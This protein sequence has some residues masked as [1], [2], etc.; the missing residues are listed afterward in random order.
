M[1]NKKKC[2]LASL[3]VGSVGIV[4]GDIGTS[5]LYALKSCFVIGNLAVSEMNVLGLISVFIWSLLL[6][7]TIKYINIVMRID[8]QGEGGIL[9]LSSIADK[10]DLGKYA[11]V[12]MFMGII[13]AALIFGDGVITP[14]ISV[15]SA[16]EG[17]Q[18]ISDHISNYILL[19]GFIILSI[20]FYIQKSGSGLIGTFFGPIMIIWFV[21]LG[22]LGLASIIQMPAILMALNPYYAVHFFMDNGLIALMT[23]GGVIL[24]VTGAEALYADMGHFG[25][26]PITLT[27][28]FFVFP[29]LVLNY[30]GQGAL[31]LASPEAIANPFYHLVPDMALY[32]MIILSTVATII[33]SQSILSGVFSL[34]WQAIMLNYLPRL[35]V[36]HTS[37]NQIGQVYVPAVNQILY[38]LTVTA[39]LTFRTSDNLAVAYGLSVS[40]CMLI[41]TCLA[42][43]VA[44]YKWQWPKI[45]LLGLFIPLVALDTTFMLTNI[46]KIV[47]GAWY[48]L[49]ITSFAS[50]VIFVWIRGSQALE[51]QKA[52]PHQGLR[53]FLMQYEEE[54]PTKIPGTAVFMTRFPTKVPN[55]LLI[56][57]HHNKFLHKKLL[58]VSI[59]IKNVP[60]TNGD[61]K[62]SVVKLSKH[63][64]VITAN[65][66]FMEVPSLR[67]IMNWAK[68]QKIMREDE[69]ISFFLSKGVP[70]ISQHTVLSRFG[71]NL[72]IFLSKNSLSAYE[73]Y[74]IPNHQVIELGVRYRV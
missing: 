38:V 69:D 5:P 45:Y 25:R 60:K 73:F 40:G 23:L 35:T 4:Y 15:L 65:F 3:M 46:V 18:L 70:V 51:S 17:L 54:N 68:E 27:W 42:F 20:L 49:L 31:L 62:Y 50:Y 52:P 55:S 33:A 53:S 19:F 29:S 43:L 16:L 1:N 12:P 41:T 28:T 7:V 9:I 47:E 26:R 48:T 22:I 44:S 34:T 39:I 59:I 56:H 10:L 37:W 30:L 63:A 72:Y 6:I 24:V 32:P 57:L 61:H 71:E 13:G 58:F 66:G 64:H 8:D 14:A 74:K 2:S 67:K 11:I 36:M 21:T